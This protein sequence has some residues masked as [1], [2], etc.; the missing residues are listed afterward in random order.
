MS[1]QPIIIYVIS[2]SVGGT[3]SNLAQA[4]L[5]QFPEIQAD[6]RNFS[7][8]QTDEKLVSVLNQAREVNAIV[9]HTLVTDNLNDITEKYCIENELTCYDLMNPLVSELSRRSNLKPT[10]KPGALHKMDETYFERISS[11]EFAVKYDDGKDPKGF[12]EADIVILGVSRTSKTPLSMFLANQN[13]KV[14]NLPLMPESSIPDEIWE[15]DSNKIV[16]LMNDREKLASIRRERMV[17]YGLNPENTY[18]SLE[19]IDRELD[20]ATKLYKKLNCLTIN[21][22]SKSIEETAA[23]IINKLKKR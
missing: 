5:V 10:K 16:G 18:S 9:L 12:L 14:A 2:D 4:A 19:R 3:A 17:S 22:S 11:I 13:Y 8:I 23:I 15:V 20:Y 21:V 1:S 7:F 6:I